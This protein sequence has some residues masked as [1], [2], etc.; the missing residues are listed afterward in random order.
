M[1]HVFQ[2]NAHNPDKQASKHAE[3]DQ[4]TEVIDFIKFLLKML[5]GDGSIENDN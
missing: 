4:I 3:N 5:E 1:F 2:K